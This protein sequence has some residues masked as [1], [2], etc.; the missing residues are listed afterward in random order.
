M[1]DNLLI[2]ACR[3]GNLELVKYLV[4]TGTPLDTFEFSLLKWSANK[5]NIETIDFLEE[6]IELNRLSMKR[7]TY[8]K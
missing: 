6:L 1:F 7:I 8:I 5:D 3:Y 4:G 2:I